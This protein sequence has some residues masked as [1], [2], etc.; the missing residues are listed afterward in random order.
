MICCFLLL[1]L[2]LLYWDCCGLG[3]SIPS[4]VQGRNFAPLSSMKRAEIVRPALIYTEPRWRKDEKRIGTI[5]FPFFAMELK[6]HS[7]H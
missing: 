6:L 2:C 4:K 7:I 5:L 1:I 3:D